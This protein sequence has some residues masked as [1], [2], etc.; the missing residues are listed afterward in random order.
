[1]NVCT[2]HRWLFDK[3]DDT[4]HMHWHCKNCGEAKITTPKTI[5]ELKAIK[6]PEED[7]NSE[8]IWCG[9]EVGPTQKTCV[10]CNRIHRRIFA[11]ATPIG[12]FCSGC[13]GLL[14]DTSGGLIKNETEHS[15]P[16][17][18]IKSEDIP[19][20]MVF[21]QGQSK[22][23]IFETPEGRIILTPI[24]EDPR[25]QKSLYDS[26]R[27]I[28]E[29][30]QGPMIDPDTMG[31]LQVFLVLAAIFVFIVGLVA[32]FSGGLKN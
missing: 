28:Q 19:E 25:D 20:A 21:N 29:T 26:P 24:E 6:Y 16:Q 5:D 30:T 1:M 27:K 15:A 4:G 31:L 12:D 8:G 13:G 10:K 22:K 32:I 18:P 14:V 3:S 9:N 2:E 23:Q 7:I 17:I 11:H